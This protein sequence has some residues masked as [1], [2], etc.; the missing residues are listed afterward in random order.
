MPGAFETE[1]I[2]KERGSVSEVPVPDT[3]G[4]RGIQDSPH[5]LIERL[6]TWILSVSSEEHAEVRFF[7]EEPPTGTDSSCH[8][9]QCPFG[10]GKVYEKGSAVHEVVGLGLEVLIEDVV[11][12]YL[13][14]GG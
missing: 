13:D 10:L 14:I 9:T 5:R 3:F 6:S 1:A 2:D 7:N 11:F 8:A 12:S 4:S